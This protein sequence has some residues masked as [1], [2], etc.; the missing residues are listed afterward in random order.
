M[1]RR[2]SITLLSGAAATWSF[3]ARAQQL[4]LPVI[5]FLDSP[6]GPRLTRVPTAKC[7]QCRCSIESNVAAR[8]PGS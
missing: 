5:G 6:P 7:G 2:D 1:R 8:A 4:A 3:A